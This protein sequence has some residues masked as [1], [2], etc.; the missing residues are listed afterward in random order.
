VSNRSLGRR[1]EELACEYL[2]KAGYTIIR[3]NYYTPR[4]EIDIIAM[5]NGVLTFVEVKYRTDLEQGHPAEA[6][7]KKKLSN[8]RAA[9]MHFFQDEEVP[10]FTDMKFDA[11]TIIERTGTPP[12]IELFEH[13]LGP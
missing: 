8:F 9:V 4:G 12:E 7:T 13:I 2:C 10:P 3:T 1:G 5:R 11:I 6:I